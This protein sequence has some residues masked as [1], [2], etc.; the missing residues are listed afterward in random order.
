MML[1]GAGPRVWRDGTPTEG[2]G[3]GERFRPETVEGTVLLEL[4]FDLP[5]VL[6][7]LLQPWKDVPPAPE[8]RTT[9]LVARSPHGRV[10]VAR[11]DAAGAAAGPPAHG[12]RARGQVAPGPG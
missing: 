1:V 10:A 4:A 2:A 7:Q 8:R 3:S 11:S 12:K 5:A 9:L 6:P